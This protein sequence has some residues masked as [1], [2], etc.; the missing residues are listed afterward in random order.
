ILLVREAG[1]KVEGLFGEANLLEGSVDILAANPVIF[2]QMRALL[3]EVRNKKDNN[4]AYE[5]QQ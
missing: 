3:I 4:D 2:P 5:W 1:G